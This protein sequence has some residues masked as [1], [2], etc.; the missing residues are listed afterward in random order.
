MTPARSASGDCSIGEI[1]V[2]QPCGSRFRRGEASRGT[3]GRAHA[4]PL[5]AGDRRHLGGSD[6]SALPTAFGRRSSARSRAA[7]TR[8][9]AAGSSLASSHSATCHASSTWL[10]SSSAI[11]SNAVGPQ[12]ISSRACLMHRDERGVRFVYAAF[13]SVLCRDGFQVSDAVS[14]R[15]LRR[16]VL[17]SKTGR[18]QAGGI[19]VTALIVRGARYRV[20]QRVWRAMP[21]QLFAKAQERIDTASLV[22]H[23][24][25]EVRRGRAAIV[26]DVCQRFMTTAWHG[27][28]RLI[29]VVLASLERAGEVVD[30]GVVARASPPPNEQ[31]GPIHVIP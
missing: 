6:C 1:V 9:R 30:R 10:A 26:L 13:D 25:C 24:P 29:R 16:Q 5:V 7:S 31:R 2:T 23:L 21:D 12:A 18:Q 19:C 14:L 4:R 17:S 20:N 3:P 8:A 22:V 27:A 11:V 15:R 28:A